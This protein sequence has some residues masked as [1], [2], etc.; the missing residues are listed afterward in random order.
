MNVRPLLD[1]AQPPDHVAISTPALLI[2][3]AAI[4]VAVAVAKD[5]ELAAPIGAAAAVAAVLVVVLTR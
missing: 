2:V 3:F 5:P 4:V 1:G